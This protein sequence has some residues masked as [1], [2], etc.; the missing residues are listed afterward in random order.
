MTVRF[1]IICSKEKLGKNREL[2]PDHRSLL[3]TQ[4]KQKAAKIVRTPAKIQRVRYS[5]GHGWEYFPITWWPPKFPHEGAGGSRVVIHE[6]PDL[7]TPL[8]LGAPQ[9]SLGVWGGNLPTWEGIGPDGT[10][11]WTM[12]YF[13]IANVCLRSMWWDCLWGKVLV[14][15]ILVDCVQYFRWLSCWKTLLNSVGKN[16]RKVHARATWLDHV[17][18]DSGRL[19]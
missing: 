15:T 8:G 10:K 18:Y 17:V 5:G 14:T 12:S 1:H 9:L 7:D 4:Y 13:F 3:M 19:V 6:V 11:L 2:K 16:L